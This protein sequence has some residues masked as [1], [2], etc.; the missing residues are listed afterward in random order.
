MSAII[1]YFC[2]E[3]TAKNYNNGLYCIVLYCIVEFTSAHFSKFLFLIFNNSI[4]FKKIIAC[5]IKNV[6]NNLN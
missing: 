2:N 6:N 1:F 5:L 3:N 4:N